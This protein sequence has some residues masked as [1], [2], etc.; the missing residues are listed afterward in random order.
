VVHY[1]RYIYLYNIV[2]T[3]TI[4]ILKSER[5]M[6]AIRQWF[7]KTGCRVDDWPRFVVRGVVDIFQYYIISPVTAVL[8]S[9]SERY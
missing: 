3:I 7:Y 6:W 2:P 4:I 1:T 8:S 9:G 5:R